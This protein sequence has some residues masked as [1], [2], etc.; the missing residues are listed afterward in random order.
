MP[1]KH[2][3]SEASSQDKPSQRLSS[4]LTKLTYQLTRLLGRTP[5]SKKAY[6]QEDNMKFPSTSKSKPLI[7]QSQK[8]IPSPIEP[9]QLKS[10]IT[11]QKMLTWTNF[12]V[13]KKTSTST[14]EESSLDSTNRMEKTSGIRNPSIIRK[15]MQDQ[16]YHLLSLQ[17][18]SASSRPS[19]LNHR[20]VGIITHPNYTYITYPGKYPQGVNSLEETLLSLPLLYPPYKKPLP[21]QASK[22][23]YWSK[24]PKRSILKNKV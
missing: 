4:S 17:N 18:S 15:S 12:I 19:S 20:Q 16:G 7:P 23:L 6:L 14:S 5:S 3:I 2:I 21:K 8:D 13:T 11:F 24:A 1:T 9:T 10:L 22:L